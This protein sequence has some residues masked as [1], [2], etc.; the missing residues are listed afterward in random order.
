MTQVFGILFWVFNTLMALW[1]G[2]AL[3][4]IGNQYARAA[5][6]GDIG[7]TFIVLAWVVGVFILGLLVRLTW[8]SSPYLKPH[9]L[10]DVLAAIQTMAL[11]ERYRNSVQGWANLISG[12]PE[13]SKYWA[14]LMATND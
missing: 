8:A 6:G 2:A 12:K 5:I 4:S 11:N 9:R 3:T 7:G 14:Q 10:N 1:V 13:D